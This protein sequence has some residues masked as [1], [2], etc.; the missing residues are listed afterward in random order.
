MAGRIVVFGATG[1]TGTL[2]A[3]AL[4]RRGQRPVLAARSAAKLA[5]LAGELGGDLDVKVADVSRPETR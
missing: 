3:Q 4:V 5:E 2:T 1:Y